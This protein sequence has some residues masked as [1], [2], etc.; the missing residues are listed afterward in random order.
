MARYPN[1]GPY[2][3]ASPGCPGWGV[4]E[5]VVKDGR[6]Y[7]GFNGASGETIAEFKAQW[8]CSDAIDFGFWQLY[9]EGLTMALPPRL[10][11]FRKRP[12]MFLTP[13]CYDTAAAF[14]LGYDEGV[15]LGLL[16]GFREW[17]VLKADGGNNFA[18]PGLVRL[19]IERNGLGNSS[20]SRR[21]E[22]EVEFLF[23]MID[24]FLAERYEVDGLRRIFL[25][26]D[27]WVRR[28]EW[29]TP[30]WPGWFAPEGP[31]SAKGK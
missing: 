6:V 7:D 20:D 23:A 26:Y 12:G 30:S 31:A 13:I 25:K 14:V 5:V 15:Q 29:Y 2:R 4:H 9:L 17:L 3:G 21:D 1:L 19:L 24:E 27:A 28:Q 18:W 10:E 11:S 16:T 8:T 22:A